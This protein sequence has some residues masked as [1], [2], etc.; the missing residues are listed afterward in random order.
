MP[1]GA[2]FASAAVSL[3][4]E[5]EAAVQISSSEQRV[6]TLRRISDLFLANAE[7]VSDAQVALFDDV[8]SHL[9][10]AVENRAL[11]ELS[12]K[13][14]PVDNA[15]RAVIQQLARNDDIA[16]ASPV[17]AL[18]SQLT[19]DDLVEIAETKTQGHLLAISGRTTIGERV[20][21]VLVE[22][23]D[24]DVVHRVAA[25]AGASFSK[26]GFTKLVKRA[27]ND[28]VLAERV[29]SR[30]DLPAP[31]LH[32]LLRRATD[33]VR[34]RI[35]QAAPAESREDVQRVLAAV[36]NEIV[37]EVIKPR[38]YTRAQA[39]VSQLKQQNRLDDATLQE[40]ANARKYEEM[41]AGL[42]LM[43]A[44]PIGMIES[45]MQ[46]VRHDGLVV[47]CKAAEL[48]WPATSAILS[49][50]FAHHATPAAQMQDAKAD[51]IKLTVPTAQRVFRFWLI[52]KN[53]TN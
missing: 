50:R 8:L 18:S 51:F 33:D 40:F 21:D 42:A 24:R 52:R 37:C 44:A 19:D 22:R 47:A 23:G 53:A 13:L 17:L 39:L 41:V 35:L 4:S 49:N 6:G 14:A 12:A 20:T 38:D 48:K 45:L 32:E 36:S 11:A 7:R 10:T 5:L 26:T 25:N 34:S 15:P 2:Q 28:G 16:V 1:P 29:G 46:D 30:L 31:L 9:A 3:I 43:C 27:E